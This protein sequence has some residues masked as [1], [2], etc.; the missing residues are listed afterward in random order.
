MNISLVE[1]FLRNMFKGRDFIFKR[2]DIF[3]V[4]LFRYVSGFVRGMDDR[5]FKD[6]SL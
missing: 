6:F 2:K 5:I 4:Y 3:V 1:Y